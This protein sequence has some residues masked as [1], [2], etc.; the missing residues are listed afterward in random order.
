VWVTR[1]EP[2]GIERGKVRV[3][4][5]ATLVLALCGAANAATLLFPLPR[6]AVAPIVSPTWGDLAARDAAGEVEQIAARLHLRSGMTV[7]DIG[8]GDG[9]DTLRLAVIVAPAGSVIAEDVTPA[10]L[11]ALRASARARRATNVRTVLGAP[12]DP[13]LAPASID[14]AIMVHMYHEIQRPYALLYNLA[15]AFRHGGLLGV[16]EL[17]RPTRFHGTPPALL[18]CELRAVGY[19]RLGLAPLTGN[20]GYF[21]IFAPPA[22]GARPRPER[23]EACGG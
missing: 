4:L 22:A 6:R 8:A 12:D 5:L 19:R 20:L 3:P 15:P 14:A 17:D 1:E 21:A 18:T 23:I 10:Y 2:V 11:Q 16:E 13:G 7:A 9:Y